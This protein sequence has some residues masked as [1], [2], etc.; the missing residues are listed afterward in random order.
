MAPVA[1]AF[2]DMDKRQGIAEAAV[3][4]AKA[5][6]PRVDLEGEWSPVRD[7]CYAAA[8]A[9]LR[10]S[11]PTSSW[12]TINGLPETAPLDLGQ[13]LQMLESAR[14][15]LDAFYGRHRSLLDS[16]VSRS[17]SIA[18]DADSAMAEAREARRRIASM[19]AHFRGYRS[20][21]EACDRLEA[22]SSLLQDARDRS[23]LA[24]IIQAVR[25]VRDA[26]AAAAHV[27]HSAPERDEQARR[28]I[29]SVRTRIEGL[30]T[31]ASEMP[32]LISA[33]L[34]D[35]NARS[36]ADLVDN[37][38]LS[39]AHIER[40]EAQLTQAVNARAEGRPDDALEYAAQAR[41]ELAEAEKHV[42]EVV[43]RLRVLRDLRADPAKRA[44]AVRFR[45]RDAQ[46]LVVDRGEVGQWGSVLDAQVAR[47]DR[48]TADLEAPH[49]DYLAYDRALGEVADFIANVV[50]RVRQ[51]TTR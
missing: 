35:F 42:D 14:A 24:A 34:R 11:D 12:E 9:Y 31:R 29:T 13:T 37:E 6:S 1:S 45:L 26:T 41:T 44:T 50:S 49:P 46:R 20:V 22:S 10:V 4:A 23:D 25:E 33:L 47:I 36:S 8:A 15:G 2:L 48:I 40:A 39:R 5:V 28:T 16:A 38:E 32:L 21:R 7:A 51:G 18:A 19:V 27:I 3:A 17:A 30:R 43:D